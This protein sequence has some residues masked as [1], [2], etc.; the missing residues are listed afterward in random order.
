MGDREKMYRQ[1]NLAANIYYQFGPT[2][3][4]MFDGLRSNLEQN[5]YE[6]KYEPGTTLK[7]ARTHL[8]TINPLLAD[9]LVGKA[10]RAALAAFFVEP[11][12]PNVH[13]ALAEVIEQMGHPEEALQEYRHVLML[14]PQNEA[15]SKKLSTQINP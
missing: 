6:A 4:K 15:A 1:F 13:L 11:N 3:K 8:E 5:R 12:N 7:N 10:Y 14:D 9:K 2:E